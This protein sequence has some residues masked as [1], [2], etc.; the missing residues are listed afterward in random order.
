MSRR[1]EVP[2]MRS[3]MNDSDVS[4]DQG[5]FASW[6]TNSL[7]MQLN[8]R[9]VIYSKAKPDSGFCFRAYRAR[10]ASKPNCGYGPRNKGTS[11]TK[12]DIGSGK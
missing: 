8:M 7:F 10:Q 12:S 11:I 1:D 2:V 5:I 3:E 6:K 9:H 4:I